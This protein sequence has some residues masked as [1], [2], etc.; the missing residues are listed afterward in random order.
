MKRRRIRSRGRRGF[1]YA[2][3]VVAVCI[4]GLASAGALSTWSMAGRVPATKRRTEMAFS[5]AV[6]E[7]ER[8][9]AQTYMNLAET[10]VA[11]PNDAYYEVTG[12]PVA[13]ASPRGFRVL[14]WVI[15]EDT[16]ANGYFD[17]GD[18]RQITVEV[19]DNTKTTRY[20]REQTFLAYGGL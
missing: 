2:E 4:L 16:V 15:T 9:K 13:S 7:L 18:L 5:L 19:W 3:L 6:M 1:T 11:S 12:A 17:T 20:D 10:A 8:L 14:S